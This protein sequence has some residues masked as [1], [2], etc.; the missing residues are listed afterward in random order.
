MNWDLS[1]FTMKIFGLES[2]LWIRKFDLS[3]MLLNFYLFI[4]LGL[5]ESAAIL[6]RVILGAR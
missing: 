4:F 6:A 5:L 2:F 3:K 1:G